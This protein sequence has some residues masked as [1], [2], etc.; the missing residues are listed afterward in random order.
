MDPP[1]VITAPTGV[2]TYQALGALKAGV[3]IEQARAEID[4][5]HTR[6]QRDRP[7]PFGATS[8]VVLPLQDKIVGPVRTRNT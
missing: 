1:Q 3:T 7:T 2:R 5:I 8:A 6:E 4:A